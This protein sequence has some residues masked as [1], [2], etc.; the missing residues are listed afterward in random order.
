MERVNFTAK[1]PA[2][3]SLIEQ[4]IAGFSSAVEKV[5]TVAPELG[6]K[7]PAGLSPLEMAQQGLESAKKRVE[8]TLSS[9]S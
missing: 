1:A 7:A 8:K 3:L 5:L 4:S 9:I 2:G 6:E